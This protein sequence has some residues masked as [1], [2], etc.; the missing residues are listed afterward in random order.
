MAC[1][2][3]EQRGVVL[4][5]VLLVSVAADQR[6]L[7]RGLR[8]MTTTQQQTRTQRWMLF[9]SLHLETRTTEPS[10]HF[11]RASTSKRQWLACMYTAMGRCSTC[12]ATASSGSPAQEQAGGQAGKRKAVSLVW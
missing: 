10:A 12:A 2:V 3:E 6:Q 8:G 11:V 4:A 1:A 5:A 7:L 9:C